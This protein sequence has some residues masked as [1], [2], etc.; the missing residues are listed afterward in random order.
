MNELIK[1]RYN[2][3]AAENEV[4][5]PEIS[6]YEQAN[7]ARQVQRELPFHLVATE[8]AAQLIMDLQDGR[9]KTAARR[10]LKYRQK[11]SLSQI[12]FIAN[13]LEQRS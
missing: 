6:E 3:K 11:S 7:S 13:I 8:Q 9:E 10:C 1:R 2:V 5:H 4:P 12:S